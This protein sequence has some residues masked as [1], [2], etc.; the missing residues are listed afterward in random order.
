MYTESWA[1]LMPGSEQG[2]AAAMGD[3]SLLVAGMT[4]RSGPGFAVLAGSGPGT[5][6][7]LDSTCSL[8]RP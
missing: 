2:A 5:E 7:L 1:A 3:Y 4:F 6:R 8:A